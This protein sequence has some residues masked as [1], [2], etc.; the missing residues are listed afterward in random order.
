VSR[1]PKLSSKRPENSGKLEEHSKQAVSLR[2]TEEYKMSAY[3]DL[4]CD[5]KTLYMQ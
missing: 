5:L 2:S 4:K 1:I 3:E